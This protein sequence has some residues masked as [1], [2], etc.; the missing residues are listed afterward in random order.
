M[1]NQE[2]IKVFSLNPKEFIASIPE[3]IKH[4]ALRILKNKNISDLEWGGY[5]ALQ[6][7]RRKELQ[8]TFV[9]NGEYSDLQIN[10]LNEI[11]R[12]CVE[13]DVKINLIATPIY[14]WEKQV[15][16]NT[17]NSY[18]ELKNIKFSEAKLFDFTNFILNDTMFADNEHLNKYGAT[19]FTLETLK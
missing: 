17:K 15:S 6:N 9:D 3:Y 12:Y 10:Y 19:L 7:K 18:Y 16:E 11:Y 8:F 4:N 1:N 2:L 5:K 13:N 14:E